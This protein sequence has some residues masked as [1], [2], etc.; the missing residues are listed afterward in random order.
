MV[1]RVSVAITVA[2]ACIVLLVGGLVFQSV[3][4]GALEYTESAGEWCEQR[5]GT[6][7]NAQVIG[8]HGGM[9]CELPN[10]TSVHMDEVITVNTTDV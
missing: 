4:V 9:H 2:V 7:H 1:D 3:S 8:P 10:G 5:N 6:L